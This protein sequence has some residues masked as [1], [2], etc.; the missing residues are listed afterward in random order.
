M[1]DTGGPLN[2][3]ASIVDLTPKGSKAEDS[4]VQCMD[5]Q[6][7]AAHMSIDIA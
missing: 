5:T 4:A 1:E 7:A 3:Q 6:E 2:Q